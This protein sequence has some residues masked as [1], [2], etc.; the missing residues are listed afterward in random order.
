VEKHPV[1]DLLH[2]IAS[3]H[4]TVKPQ[5]SIQE[6]R[7]VLYHGKQLVLTPLQ[8]N[9]LIG[10]SNAGPLGVVEVKKFNPLFRQAVL[11]MFTFEPLR[12]KSQMLALGLFKK[13][14]VVMPTFTDMDLFKVF[15]DYD[16]NNKGF[17]EPS[18]FYHCLESFKPL[19][20]KPTEITTLVLLCDCEMDMRIDYAM[21]MP[22]FRDFLFQIKFNL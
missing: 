2:C 3:S 10:L 8:I 6:L 19:Y 14:D 12:Q 15:R 22:L 17:L 11:D 1:D 13:T 18:E 4:D 20:L 7:E 16:S 21:I 5:M 9:I